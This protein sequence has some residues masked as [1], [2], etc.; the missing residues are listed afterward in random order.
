M[1]S[2]M[3]CRFLKLIFVD[4]KTGKLISQTNVQFFFPGRHL[5]LREVYVRQKLRALKGNGKSQCLMCKHFEEKACL[6]F[7]SG[8]VDSSVMLMQCFSKIQHKLKFYIRL[9]RGHPLHKE[10]C[11]QTLDLYAAD[12][13]S[14]KHK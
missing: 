13:N 14:N 8:Y 3:C 11:L 4:I 9:L 6:V 7:L 10:N 1:L 12:S 2:E 5:Y